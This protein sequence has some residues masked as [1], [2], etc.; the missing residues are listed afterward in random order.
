M[1]LYEKNLV[2]LVFSVE[3]LKAIS[4]A[5]ENNEYGTIDNFK[6]I[7]LKLKGEIDHILKE[8]GEEIY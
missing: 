8:L 3:E 6:S 4:A 1:F 5:L 2:S 7:D